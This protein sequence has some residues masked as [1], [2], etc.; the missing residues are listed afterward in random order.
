MRLLKT[1]ASEVHSLRF[2]PNGVSLYLMSFEVWMTPES[3]GHLPQHLY[4]LD[5]KTG[6]LAGNWSFDQ[7]E[8]AILAPDFGALY[9]WP[10]AEPYTWPAGTRLYRL[11]LAASTRE[12]VFRS[13]D[14]NPPPTKAAFT[15]DGLTLALGIAHF[16]RWG[17]SAYDVIHRLDVRTRTE[18][19]PL[20][21]PAVCIGY[22]W[23]GGSLATGGPSGVCVWGGDP[24]FIDDEWSAAAT[25]LGWSRDGQLVWGTSSQI[26]LAR[27]GGNDLLSSWQITGDLSVLEFSPDSRHL[28]VGTTQGWCFIQDVATGHTVSTFDWGIGPIHSVAFSPDGLTCAAGGEKGQVV[29]WDVDA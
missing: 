1:P 24:A 5:T 13:D 11:D 16:P 2:A 15:P 27:P 29:V 26:S 28:L 6:E 8:V 19:K 22:S 23:D 10:A 25:A 18:L 7:S 12:I 21:G 3:M 4:Q 9:Y 17:S 14:F 20:H